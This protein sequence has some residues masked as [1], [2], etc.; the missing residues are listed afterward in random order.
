MGSSELKDKAAKGIFW[1]GFS[2]GAQ[3]IL[4]LIFGIFL[5]RLLSPGDYGV[6]GMLSI[7]TLIAGSIQDS[8]FSAAL[9]NEKEDNHENMCSVFWF[10]ITMSFILYLILYFCAP[11]IAKFYHNPDLIQLSRYLFISLF[12][13]SFS[14]VQGAY[15]TKHLMIK[16]R[17]IASLTATVISGCVGIYMAFKGFAYWGIATQT[18][19]YSTVVVICMWYFSPW[20]PSFRFSF[21]PI[22]R[23]FTFSCKLL[24]TSIFT[25]INNN[26]FSVI[27]GRLYNAREVGNYSQANKWNNMGS[28]LISNMISGVSR[29]VLAGV[30][31]DRE[32]QLRIFR[33]MIRFTAFCSFPAMFGLALV[34]PE[35]ITVAITDKWIDSAQIMRILCIGGAF[36]PI[37]SLFSSLVISNGKSDTYM[38]CTVILGILQTAM[39]VLMKDFGIRY[40]LWAYT[41]LNIL[42]VLVWNI[43]CKHLIGY[44]IGHFIMDIAPY[45]AISAA[46]MFLTFFCTKGISNVYILLPGRVIMAASMYCLVMWASKAATFKESV[47][48]LTSL[49]KRGNQ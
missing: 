4:N 43:S 48:Y 23:M 44:G 40:M 38:L 15:L 25:H 37:S 49:V 39:L 21:K 46:I 34:A 29:P 45:I 13:S 2:N 42:W 27:L 35:F 18:I 3:Q 5:A 11:L 41:A 10:N 26:I 31:D 32:R 24:I 33:K 28:D 17:A 22:K 8:G 36:L 9:I 14:C 12:I 47:L 1:G 7:F 20:R 16:E 30:N 19:T 6:I